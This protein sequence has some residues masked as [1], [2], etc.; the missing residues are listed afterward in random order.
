MASEGIQQFLKVWKE[1]KPLQKGTLVLILCSLISA[2]VYL[3]TGPSA[4]N[5]ISLNSEISLQDSEIE[6]VKNYLDANSIR[7]KEGRNQ[8]LLLTRENVERVRKE[9]F[10]T[11]FSHSDRSKGF[12]LFDTNTWIKG[13]KELQVLEMRALK[14][15]LEQDLAEFDYIKSASVILDIPPQKSFGGAHYK[16]KASVIL[17]LMPS[18]YLSPSQLKAITYHLA[19][20]VRGLEPNMIAISD[21]TGKLYKP[22]DPEGNGEQFCCVFEDYLQDKVEKFLTKLFGRDHYFCSLKVFADQGINQGL[23]CVSVTLDKSL[24]SESDFPQTREEVSRQIENLSNG[25]DIRVQTIIDFLPFEKKRVQW[26][27]KPEKAG[28]AGLAATLV[29]VVLALISLI[30]LFRRFGG[31][32]KEA[33]SEKSL[34]SMMTGIDIQKLADSMR[35]E[36]PETIALMVSYLEPSRAEKLIAAFSEEYQEQILFYLSEMEKEEV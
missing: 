25:L 16:T 36:D 31:K 19:G 3:K 14:G 2:L 7:Y 1:I 35:Q 5:L 9:C 8:E 10:S 23:A 4:S 15:Q 32:K 11:P 18:I 26:I 27:E 34:I 6:S 17:T 24:F 22:I 28:Y 21:T 13:E 20:A 12:E 33:E 30:P 29:V